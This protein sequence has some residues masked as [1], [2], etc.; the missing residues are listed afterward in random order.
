[1]KCALRPSGPHAVLVETRENEVLAAAH[2]LRRWADAAGLTGLEV[3]PG[4]TTVLLIAE[5]LGTRS[6]L[7]R[8]LEAALNDAASSPSDGPDDHVGAVVELPVIYDGVDLAAVADAVDMTVDA[9]I[10]SHAEANYRVAF[11]GF[12]PGFAY[13]SGLPDALHLPRRPTPRP[14]VPAGSVAVAA[15]YCG[16][17]P[18]TSPGGWYLLGRTD[19]VLWSTARRPPALLTPGTRVR[20]VPL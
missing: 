17:Y 5:G 6:L 15:G 12:A 20:F 18:R 13:L 7:Y 10:R 19:I 4:A 14:R 8:D 11:C 16:V 9:V 1:M 3:V 2:A